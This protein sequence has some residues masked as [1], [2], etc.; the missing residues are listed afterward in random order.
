MCKVSII[1]PVYNKE[2]YVRRAIESI[3]SQTFHEWELI[4]VDDGSTD[5]SYSICREYTDKRIQVYHVE[6]G[7]VSRVRNTGLT[8]AKGEYVTFMDSDD[9]ISED[10]L[11]KL[12]R[13]EC[14]M[15]IAGLT[16]V[17]H[18]GEKVSI[19]FPSLNGRK[20]L[21]E[22]ADGFYK[23]QINTGIYG[24]V[25]GKLIR[26]QIIEQ[27]HIQF[28]E[29]IRLAEDYDFYLKIY[30]K[31]EEIYFLHYAGYYYLQDTEN[32]GISFQDEKT[33][34]FIQGEIQNKTKLFLT[35]MNCFG[36]EEERIYAERMT[37]YVY[38]IL[39]LNKGLSYKKFVLLFSRLKKEFP[40]V[41]ENVTGMERWCISQY[42]RNRRM[43]IYLFLKLR[44]IMGK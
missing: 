18:E 25:A 21:Q 23:E 37:G 44:A 8:Y 34:F 41:T 11:E 26:R 30:Q 4:I 14:D 28:D 38:T 12:Y 40:E 6:N 2:K 31:I 42:K 16:K 3:L 9:Y 17:N 36:K 39:L 15:V 19:V 1:M 5:S 20:K 43:L 7:G 24:F 13:P 29:R 10:Y 32:S 35:R 22:V 27:N 33:D